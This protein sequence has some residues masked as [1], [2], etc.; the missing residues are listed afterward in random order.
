MLTMTNEEAEP[1]TPELTRMKNGEYYFE[2][3]PRGA[4]PCSISRAP[5]LTQNADPTCSTPC[6]ASTLF[7]WRYQNTTI[8]GLVSLRNITISCQISSLVTNGKRR[9]LITAS[10][11][12]DK[13]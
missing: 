9:I 12:C 2:S 5:E 13:Q 7:G 1:Y 11:G 4:L 10:T 8:T 6:T 3:V